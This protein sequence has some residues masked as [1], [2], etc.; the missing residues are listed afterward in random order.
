MEKLLEIVVREYQKVSGTKEDP[1]VFL[2]AMHTEA[3]RKRLTENC[4][5]KIMKGRHLG[6][7]ES[8]VKAI[9]EAYDFL[10]DVVEQI[11]VAAEEISG[12][13]YTAKQPL[14]AE[15]S[16]R[17]ICIYRYQIC[18]M[19]F[20]KYKVNYNGRIVELNTAEDIASCVLKN[21]PL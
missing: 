8:V 6:S 2:N 5:F 14:F 3:L 19:M 11:L 7:L 10:D 17:Y 15:F 13:K 4:G 16:E 20:D 21:L 1:K 12:K 18:Q 9:A